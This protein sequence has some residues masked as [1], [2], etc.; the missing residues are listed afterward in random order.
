MVNSYTGIHTHKETQDGVKRSFQGQGQK[1]LRLKVKLKVPS[2]TMDVHFI[3]LTDFGRQTKKLQCHKTNS[4]N[5]STIRMRSR[6]LLPRCIQVVRTQEIFSF[7]PLGLIFFNQYSLVL[8]VPI[9]H[10]NRLK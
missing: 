2:P 9:F 7:E 4:S 5:G 1:S 3:L 10:P 8:T 6:V